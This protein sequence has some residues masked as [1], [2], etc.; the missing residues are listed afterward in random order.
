M[1][2]ARDYVD[3]PISSGEEDAVPGQI[4]SKSP[5]SAVDVTNGDSDAGPADKSPSGVE[6]M[7]VDDENGERDKHANGDD[8]ENNGAGED[9]D[10]D[11]SEP[12][13]EVEAIIGAR[14]IKGVQQ[15]HIKWKGF[16]E[17]DNT[18]EPET[19]IHCPDLVDAYWAEHAEKQS[20]KA[21]AKNSARG[22]R[23][24]LGGS[25]RRKRKSVDLEQV[26]NI[27]SEE[28]ENDV[29]F[30]ESASGRR[31]AKRRRGDSPPAR[32]A[33]RRNRNSGGGLGAMSPRSRR[34][35]KHVN[36]KLADPEKDLDS[37]SGESIG[38]GSGLRGSLSSWDPLV[39][40]IENVDEGERKGEL[41]VFIRWKNGTRSEES[42]LIANKKCPQAIIK[43][44]ESHI[45]FKLPENGDDEASTG[46]V[47]G[48]AATDRGNTAELLNTPASAGVH[49]E[50]LTDGTTLLV[51]TE[52]ET[53]SEMRVEMS[54]DGTVLSSHTT[55]S[56]TTKHVSS[57]PRA[58]ALAES[59]IMR[60]GEDEELDFVPQT[61]TQSAPEEIQVIPSP[62]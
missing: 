28:D 18:W 5:T 59:I 17:D 48:D 61:Q 39:Q 57:P 41:R 22:N 31:P 11:E 33:V 45:R 30:D 32:R 58:N 16:D 10:E 13:W 35:V 37:D 52:K 29:E 20:A 27:E 7:I 2:T 15:Y 24:V 25:D 6:P 46:Y 51:S 38:A 34:P 50:D 9:E 40:E 23:T 53:T 60:E 12:E 14:K 49:V 42:A 1:A 4:P 8:K 55:T 36:Y 56:I 54:A 43:F 26:F 21:A 44:Y 47:D 62:L 19:N 3:D